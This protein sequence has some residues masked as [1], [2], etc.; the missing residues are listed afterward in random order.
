MIPS[1][2]TASFFHRGNAHGESTVLVEFAGDM[3][4]GPPIHWIILFVV[5]VIGLEPLIN[6]LDGLWLRR[7][8]EISYFSSTLELLVLFGSIF[9]ETFFLAEVSI[10][11]YVFPFSVPFQLIVRCIVLL[12]HHS[13]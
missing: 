9:W 1:V 7:G 6:L 13:P 11:L 12:L 5:G 10:L 2:T 8:E 3:A 4:L